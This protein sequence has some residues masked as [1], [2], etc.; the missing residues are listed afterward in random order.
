MSKVRGHFF[1]RTVQRFNIESRTDKLLARE[2]PITAPQFK[3]DRELLAEIRKTRPDIVDAA[4]KKDADLLNK[5]KTVYVSSEDPAAFDPEINS[6]LKENPERPLPSRGVRGFE[7]P[8][9][10]ATARTMGPGKPGRLSIDDILDL[11]AKGAEHGKSV[12]ALAKEYNLPANVVGSLGDHYEIFK[13]MPKSTAQSEEAER[14][15]RKRNDP[16][17][18]QDDWEDAS[19]TSDSKTL[20][21]S[22]IRPGLPGQN[23]PRKLT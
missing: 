17:R 20:P 3:S 13:F 7:R 2:K 23:E 6:K 11:L 14:E 16:Y 21:E 9:F 4:T 15:R 5:L 12:E 19:V 18:A 22:Q 1:T 10:S 8:G